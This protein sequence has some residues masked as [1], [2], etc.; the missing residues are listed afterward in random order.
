MIPV[1]VITPPPAD[2]VP[3]VLQL[4]GDKQMQPEKS[5]DG[6]SEFDRAPLRAITNGRKR[7]HGKT[8][9]KRRVFEKENI[10]AHPNAPR[11]PQPRIAPS[12]PR[13]SRVDS[14]PSIAPVP[15]EPVV[16]TAEP[17]SSE[18]KREKSQQLE[19]ARAWSD[20]IL[21]RRRS[22]PITPA[23]PPVSTQLAR[24]ASAP[25]RMPLAD[26][27]RLAVAGCAT[28]APAPTVIPVAP[29]WGDGNVSFV[30]GD[31]EEAE[32]EEEVDVVRVPI[33]SGLPNTELSI[34]AVQSQS[35][36][37]PSPSTSSTSLTASSSSSSSGYLSSILDAFE[38]EFRAPAW[39]GLKQFPGN[40]GDDGHEE[41][42]ADNESAY[43]GLYMDDNEDVTD[44]SDH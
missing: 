27:L 38:E 29:L 30:L 28:P 14:H 3:S 22:L 42:L 19:Q 24:R 44:D 7:V 33:L 31:E 5:D 39:L 35:S 40:G 8:P 4:P 20:A 10:G 18:W 37:L 9:P 23:L 43:G 13:I 15:A 17:G 2:D 26:R 16:K 6:E 36:P 1:I 41:E 25:A 11:R 34:D 32:E 21:A 12:P